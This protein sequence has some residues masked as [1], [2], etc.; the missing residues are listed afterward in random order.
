MV[1]VQ[2]VLQSDK[3]M[4]SPPGG[5]LNFERWIKHGL[6][7]ED[8]QDIDNQ[9]QELLSQSQGGSHPLL[10]QHLNSIYRYPFANGV[11]A[12]VASSL[13]QPDGSFSPFCYC[14]QVLISF[15]YACGYFCISLLRKY[16]CEH[17]EVMQG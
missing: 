14:L 5:N 4:G 9:A 7:A 1:D 16:S 8:L 12:A 10:V 13:G 2:A 15:S 11:H 6:M 3:G 17:S